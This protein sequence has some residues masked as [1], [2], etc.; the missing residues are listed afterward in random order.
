VPGR[1]IWQLT[2]PKCCTCLNEEIKS[3]YPRLPASCNIDS[4]SYYMLLLQ[5]SGRASVSIVGGKHIRLHDEAHPVAHRRVCTSNGS[6][7]V[8]PPFV[9]HAN[10]ALKQFARQRITHTHL[11]V[12]S[13][14]ER[15]VTVTTADAWRADEISTC[16]H[17]MPRLHLKDGGWEKSNKVF[18][19]ARHVSGTMARY[20]IRSS[21]IS[22]SRQHCLSFYSQLDRKDMAPSDSTTER[23]KVTSHKRRT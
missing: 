16:A 5:S 2:L 13:R 23:Y 17:N 9:T 3:A 22:S 15:H 4:S 8:P 12:Q 20:A 19:T 18:C 6:R 11:L 10:P 21:C 14:R 7:P 1:R